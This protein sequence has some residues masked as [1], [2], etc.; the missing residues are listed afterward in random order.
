MLRAVQASDSTRLDVETA[1]SKDLLKIEDAVGAFLDH[2]QL[3]HYSV[4]QRGGSHIKR[5]I[6]YIDTVGGDLYGFDM[7]EVNLRTIVAWSFDHGHLVPCALL[8]DNVSAGL[9]CAINGRPWSGNQE[10]HT[11]MFREDGQRV[12]TD[13]VGCVSV[14]RDTISAYDYGSNVLLGTLQAQQS[15]GH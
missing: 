12:G 3:C 15:G 4:D 5:W 2:T 7:V 9:C 8:N 6:P 1:R 10:F 11:V 14:R 13:L